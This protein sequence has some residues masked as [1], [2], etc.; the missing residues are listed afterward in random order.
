L[1]R[2]DN[3]RAEVQ[4]FIEEL[5][6]L[7]KET[8]PSKGP[9]SEKF[10]LHHAQNAIHIWW[11]VYGYLLLW[12]QSQI[13]GYEIARESPE[14]AK[15]LFKSRDDDLTP[16]SHELE[17]LG[18]TRAYNIPNRQEFRVNALIE[19]T[20]TFQE[21]LNDDVLRRVIVRL[22]LTTELNSSVWIDP[23]VT[24]LRA[25]DAGELTSLLKPSKTRRRGQPYQLDQ[26]RSGAVSHVHYLMGK[27]KKKY[28]AQQRVADALAVSTDTL[29][30]WEKALKED[31]FYPFFWSGAYLAGQLEE[32]IKKKTYQDLLEEYGAEFFGSMSDVGVARDFL[33]TKD[34]EMSVERLRAA[35][36]KYH[37]RGGEGES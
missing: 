19:A 30:D 15:Q 22:L 17:L 21:G 2:E 7:Y 10:K 3:I 4:P 32:E 28:I 24:A 27:G 26:A 35:L 1:D 16:D 11:R 23:L 37:D 18:L 8:D 31:E 13:V 5:Y 14:Y 34:G 33:E 6:E 36:R 12:A 9:E 20:E 29:R 25:V